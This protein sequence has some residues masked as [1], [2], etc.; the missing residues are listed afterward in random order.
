MF[1][2]KIKT[3][4]NLKSTRKTFLLFLDTDIFLLFQLVCCLSRIGLFY[5]HLNATLYLAILICSML[6]KTK[7]VMFIMC[8]GIGFLQV[9]YK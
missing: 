3:C 9:F 1:S 5:I 8:F 7:E 2:S 4:F 6:K